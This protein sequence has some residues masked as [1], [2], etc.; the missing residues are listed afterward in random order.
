MVPELRRRGADRMTA[1]KR[2]SKQ[3]R[4]QTKLPPTKLIVAGVTLSHPDRVY[5]DD[6]GV[7][8]RALAEFYKTIW[9]WAKPHMVGRPIALLRCPDGA[10]K[11]CFFQKHAAAGIATEHLHLVP[12]K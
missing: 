3:R 5:W 7:T 2:D 6:A 4:N 11:Q 10:A 1:K 9:R 8:K 12:E